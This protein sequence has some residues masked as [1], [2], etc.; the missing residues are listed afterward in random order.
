MTRP[1]I[2]VVDDDPKIV[3]VVRAYLEKDGYQVLTA[4]DGCRALE[5][6]R[7]ARPDLVV[8][9]LMLPGMDGLDICHVLRSEGNRTPIIMLTARTTEEDKLLGLEEGADDYVTKPFSPRE[10]L[11]RI[12]AVLRRA[13]PESGEEPS[14]LRYGALTVDP[15]RYEV[16]VGGEPVTLTRTEFKLLTTLMSEAGKVFTRF[17]LLER[18]FGYDYEGLERTVD[19]HVMNLRRKIEPD[20]SRPTYIQTVYGVGYKFSEEQRVS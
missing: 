11:A 10:L 19:V 7:E 6:T 13:G 1:R 14:V 5:L 17:D 20:P 4:E 9:D 16:K 15:V 3:A 18:L 2:L 8:L 12:R